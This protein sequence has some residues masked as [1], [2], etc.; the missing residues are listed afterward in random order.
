ML[1][2]LILT[3]EQ[4]DIQLQIYSDRNRR[5]FNCRYIQIGIGEYST[6]EIFRQEQEYIQ[7]QKKFRQEQENIQLQIYLD[8]NRRIFS[9]RNI[10]IEIGVYSAAKKFRQEQENIQLQ[11]Y[12]DRNRRIFNCRYIQ[13]GIGEYSAADIFRQDQEN[14]QL[15]MSATQYV[16]FILFQQ[17]S[18]IYIMNMIKTTKF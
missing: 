11:I 16:Q 14:I 12:L 1:Q 10:Q 15:H 7:L 6:A 2:G 9:C 13:I 17:W 5:I 18:T 8:R 3:F 4:E